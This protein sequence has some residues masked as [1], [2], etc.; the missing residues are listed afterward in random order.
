MTRHRYAELDALRGIAALIVVVRHFVNIFPRDAYPVADLLVKAP[1]RILFA[2]HEAVLLF[3]LLSGF[4]LATS[5]ISSG[6]LSSGSMPS[7]AGYLTFVRKRVYRIYPPY[8]AAVGLAALGAICLAEPITGLSGWFGLTWSEPVTL[9][10]LADHLLLVGSF[11]TAQ[12]NTAFWSLVHEMRISLI[13]PALLLFTIRTPLWLVAA[14]AAGATAL[15]GGSS[16]YGGDWLPTFHYAGIFALGAVMARSIEAIRARYAATSTPVRNAAGVIAVLLVMYGLGPPSL[17][18]H[19]GYFTDWFVVAGLVWLMVLA[20]SN[21]RVR[22]ILNLPALQYLGRVSYSL[23]L[24]HATM[25]FAL[26]HLL[27][28]WLVGLLYL[29][30]SFGLTAIFHMLIEVPSIGMAREVGC[31]PATTCRAAHGTGTLHAPPS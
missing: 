1:T 20:L 4:V 24:V 11:D 5:I 2:A 29:P 25:L 7:G 23:Y 9:R 30:L 22:A 8:A 14:A 3:F 21:E 26:V 31:R 19:L 28:V 15:A 18:E 12:L 6:G 27:P 16:P 10:I 17:R 13:F